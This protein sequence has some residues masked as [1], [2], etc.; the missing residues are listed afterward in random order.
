[1][2][3]WSAL[4]VQVPVETKDNA[5]PLVIVQTPVVLEVKLTAR[6]DEAV[7][8][9]VGVVPKFWA[10][11]AANVMVCADLVVNETSEP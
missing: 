3:A 7:A 5:P 6:V 4:M 11:G 9:S 2:P 10:S 8:A 1:M